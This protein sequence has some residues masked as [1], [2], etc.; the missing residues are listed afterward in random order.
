MKLILS[1]VVILMA[2]VGILGMLIVMAG[3]NLSG[4]DN[5]PENDSKV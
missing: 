3:A 5:G 4:D 1:I 2:V